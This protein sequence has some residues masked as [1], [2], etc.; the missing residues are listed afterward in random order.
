M[1]H[2][3][4]HIT[5]ERKNIYIINHYVLTSIRIWPSGF[6]ANSIVLSFLGC[7]TIFFIVDA[8]HCMC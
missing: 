2:T 7:A 8:Y 1:R 3:S 5:D 6:Q 4:I